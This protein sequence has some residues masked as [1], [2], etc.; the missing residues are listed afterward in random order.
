L[1]QL[2]LL[3]KYQNLDILVDNCEN[4]RKSSPLRQKLIELKNYLTDQQTLLLKLEAETDKKN[5][6]L[7]R[8]NHE[9]ESCANELVSERVKLE[10]EHVK[11]LRQTEQMRDIALEIKERLNRK[12]QELTKLLDEINTFEKKLDSI[13]INIIRAKKEYTGV[14]AKYDEEFEIFQKESAVLKGDR[15]AVGANVD[16]SLLARYVKIKDRRSTAVVMIENERCGGCNMMLASVLLQSIRDKN[17]IIE[18]ENCGRLLYLAA[19]KK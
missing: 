7:N 2:D 13:R 14:K 1:E 16:V 15:D 12:S 8:I 10:S 17:D 3:L 6:V 11:T 18:C 19:K 4:Q 5:V 9:F